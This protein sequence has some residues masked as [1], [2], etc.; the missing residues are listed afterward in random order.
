MRYSGGR[1]VYLRWRCLPGV[2][3]ELVRELQLM[4]GR[5][6][7]KRLY[8]VSGHVGRVIR[9]LWIEYNVQEIR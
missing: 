2:L 1:E 9:E 7:L 3:V 8:T 5:A 4:E 6:A